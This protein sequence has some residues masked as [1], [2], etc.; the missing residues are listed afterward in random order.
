MN[1]EELNNILTTLSIED[2]DSVLS[3]I[4]EYQRFGYFD[5][6]MSTL[7]EM[8]SKIKDKI[9][10]EIDNL[11]LNNIDDVVENIKNNQ[12]KFKRYASKLIKIL[13][14][15]DLNIYND[16]YLSD[17]NG[18]LSNLMDLSIIASKIEETG[19]IKQIDRNKEKL[20]KLF[21]SKQ[22]IEKLNRE[23]LAYQKS[24]LNKVND[25]IIFNYEISK[26]DLGI[27][28]DKYKNSNLSLFYL[29]LKDAIDN[30]NEQYN[31]L[32]KYIKNTKYLLCNVRNSFLNKIN[33]VNDLL[34][35]YL[36]KNN[37]DI[38]ELK[39]EVANIIKVKDE[40]NRAKAL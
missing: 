34:Y 31:D 9:N 33:K 4:D 35:N 30:K 5:Y 21:I 18:K 6:I 14:L 2:L 38:N 13:E 37:I 12:E 11:S 22:E 1:K 25:F 19:L 23:N 7:E 39:S 26:E 8:K 24:L 3:I 29:K 20:K 40:T 10:I 36:S 17:K 27:N 32:I 16:I 28:I 15:I